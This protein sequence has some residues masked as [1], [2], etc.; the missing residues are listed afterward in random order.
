MKRFTAVL[1]LVEILVCAG[2]RSHTTSTP[3]QQS[4]AP[5]AREQEFKARFL[6][7]SAIQR[8]EAALPDPPVDRGPLTR[9]EGDLMLAME[10]QATPE[11]RARANTE[12]TLRVWVLAD[13]LG[14]G[15]NAE[16]MPLTAALMRQ[17]ERESSVVTRA[18][19]ARWS[20]VRPSNQDDR[21]VPTIGVP[22]DGSYPSGHSV[23]SMLWAHLLAE[24]APDKAD[25]LIRRARLVA[26]DRVIGGVHYPT[27]VAAGMTVGALIAEE[28]MRSPEYLAEVA[29]ARAEWPPRAQ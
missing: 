1:L 5:S 8:L 24:F 21:I 29:R 19:K 15:F 3:V 20:R 25:A 27:D 6:D 10:A 4:P 16:A 18:L 17:A 9:G 22:E 13:V 2:C 7:A 14:P 23:R 28:I 11:A 12:E 26:Y